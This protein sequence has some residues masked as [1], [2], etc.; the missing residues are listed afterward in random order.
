[1]V[2]SFR[3]PHPSG[4]LTYSQC[5]WPTRG[6]IWG[7]SPVCNGRRANNC[8]NLSVTPGDS[9]PPDLATGPSSPLGA[10]CIS[11]VGFRKPTIVAKLSML[12]LV[13]WRSGC[14]SRRAPYDI[15]LGSNQH[16]HRAGG[17]SPPLAGYNSAMPTWTDR[18]SPCCLGS[19]SARS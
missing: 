4:Q 15:T 16:L 12:H 14:R 10:C 7:M 13:Q 5:I 9:P 8:C 2:C 17:H 11:R 1:M 3:Q 6:C 19:V 18:D